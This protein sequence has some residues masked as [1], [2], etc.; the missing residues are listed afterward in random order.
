MKKISILLLAVITLFSCKQEPPKDYVTL[1]G[2]ITNKKD[3]KLNILGRNFQ[4]TI[5]V[6]EDGTFKDTL[7]VTDGF[8]GFNN[9]NQQSFIY[10][11]NGYDLTLN[12]DA[13]DFPGSVE[14]SGNGSGTNQYLIDKLDFIEK[15]DLNN[16]KDIFYLDKP[17]FDNKINLIET[18]TQE[19]L[20][21]AKDLDTAF[22]RKEKEQNKKIID[23]F[24]ANYDTEHNRMAQFAPGKPSPKFNYP[25][26]NG[27]NVSLDDLKGKYVYVDVWATWCAPCKRE[28]PY[29]KQL[30]EEFKD[31][32]IVFVS[33]SIDKAE[34]KAKWEEMVKSK[35][36]KGVQ[37]FADNNWKSDFVTAYGIT[38]IPRFILIDKEGNIFDADAPRPSNPQL[39][40]VLKELNL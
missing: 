17:E 3:N 37:I 20:D 8:H 25:D 32:D 38:G 11:K 1:S 31:K 15:Q 10:L 22:I 16:M 7:K 23:F 14:F 29:L 36:L 9:S 13:D 27:K 34:D 6:N 18:Q 35:G 26:I 30:N 33:M 5:E 40:E 28:I 21:N 12:F 24:K 2:K 19:L 4:K 39:K